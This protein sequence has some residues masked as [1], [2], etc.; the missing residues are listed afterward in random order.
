MRT[1]QVFCR[2]L[3]A[4][5]PIPAMISIA[6]LKLFSDKHFYGKKKV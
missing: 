3:T 5:E 6:A 4:L 2:R 1:S